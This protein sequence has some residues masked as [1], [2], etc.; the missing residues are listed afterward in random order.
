MH[1]VG[2]THETLDREGEVPGL[3][4]GEIVHVALAEASIGVLTADRVV[5]TVPTA[6]I[7]RKR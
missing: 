4:L 1:E 7:T 5:N 3:G 6:Q 2:E